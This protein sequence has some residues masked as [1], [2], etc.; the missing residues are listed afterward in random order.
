MPSP[1]ISGE[2]M[3][4]IDDHYAEIAEEG[5]FIN[6]T[7]D[8][9]NFKRFWRSQKDVWW[10][11]G[12]PLPGPLRCVAVPEACSAAKQ[13]AIAGQP[14]FQIVEKRLDRA[15]IDHRQSA[16]VFRQHSR[17]HGE[18]RRFRLAAGSGRQHD[19]VLTGQQLRDDGILKRPQF[20]PAEAVDDVVL[21]RGMEKIEVAHRSSE[22]SSTL[23]A[24]TASRSTGVSSD[25]ASVSV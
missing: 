2:G 7:G 22:M 25:S 1:V 20:A 10:L 4:F 3:D 8:Q 6:A 24:P 23:F 13:F 11:F 15:D 5:F 14:S 18:D 17:E 16:P 12:D 21:Q 19:H 9:H